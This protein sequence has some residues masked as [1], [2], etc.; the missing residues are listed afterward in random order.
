MQTSQKLSGWRELAAEEGEVL[1]GRGRPPH[2]LTVA[3]KRGL[4]NKWA[5]LGAS[6]SRP[7]R[8]TR[9]RIRA[10]S[11]RLDPSFELTPEQTELKILVTEQTMATGTPV[12]DRLLTPEL[13]LDESE[14]LVRVY[15][16]P[17]E[18]YIG[19]TSRYETPVI[20]ALPEPLAGRRVTDGALYWPPAGG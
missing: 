11:W 13:Y 10:S 6:N 14:V 1:F 8:A 20:I 16:Q 17:L 19:R 18:G 9:E 4:R 2:L 5:P 7:L 3:A 15:V 12:A